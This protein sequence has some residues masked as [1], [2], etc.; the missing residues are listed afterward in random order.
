MSI[1]VI[2]NFVIKVTIKKFIPKDI[3]SENGEIVHSKS[4]LNNLGKTMEMWI[5][6]LRKPSI[7]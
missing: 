3:T 5:A 4:T 7:F 1:V 6:N 2:F